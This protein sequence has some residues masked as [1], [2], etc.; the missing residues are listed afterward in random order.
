MKKIIALL[1]GLFACL[2]TMAQDIEPEKSQPNQKPD[3]Y[4]AVLKGESL[5]MM[6][7]EKEMTA[8]V[9]LN[10][11]GTLKPNGNI[12]KKDGSITALK[13]GDCIDKD[14]NLVK[15]ITKEKEKKE[16]VEKT[17]KQKN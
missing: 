3:K 16:R 9:I 13:V 11:G 14:G 8:E 1:A 6:A 2:I 4:C 15:S 12:L 10:N 17:T 7:G 5:Q